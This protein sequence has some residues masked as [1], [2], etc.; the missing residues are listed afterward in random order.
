MIAGFKIGLLDWKEKLEQCRKLTGKYP[1]FVEI[2][3]RVDKIPQYSLMFEFLQQNNIKNGLHFWGVL[4]SGIEPN[5]LSRHKWISNQSVMLIQKAIKVATAQKS[6]YV[7]V[8]PG[9]LKERILNLDS[10]NFEMAKMPETSFEE[11]REN[12]LLNAKRLKQ[13]SEKYGVLLT[14]ETL[15]TNCPKNWLNPHGGENFL[16]AKQC[17][18]EFFA[19][20][21]REGYSVANDFGHT[22]ASVDLEQEATDQKLSQQQKREIVLKHLFFWTHKMALNTR[23]IHSN[24]TLPPFDGVDVHLGLQEEDFKKDSLPNK[25]ELIELLTVFRDRDDVYVLNEP[26]NEHVEN[27]MELLKLI[28]F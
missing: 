26:E 7:N 28:R 5:L 3:F 14:F 13:I 4:K 15:P 16:V 2:Y 17:P 19:D 12:L 18:I 27:Y 21:V 6:V 25:K 20:L 24:L 23:L 22:A 8:H 10:Q 1:S 11:G 9:A